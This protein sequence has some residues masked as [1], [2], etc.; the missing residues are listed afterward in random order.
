MKLSKR[1]FAT[2]KPVIVLPISLLFIGQSLQVF[3]QRVGIG[4][5]QPLARLAID[6]GLMVDQLSANMGSL[7]P[8]VIFGKEGLIG[9]ASSRL[10][11]SAYRNSLTFYTGGLR[12]MAI[13]SFGYVGI[14]VAPDQ[15]YRFYVNGTTRITT[16]LQVGTNLFVGNRLM[17]NTAIPQ[18]ALLYLKGRSG[19]PTGWGAHIVME[20]PSTTETGA[21][22]YD[23]DMKFRV[24][25]AGNGYFFR[26]ENNANLM[27][28]SSSGI[29]VGSRG[30]VKSNNSDQLQLVPYLSPANIDFTL[31]PGVS[32][33]FG[34]IYTAF[35]SPPIISPAH[36]TGV[37]DASHLNCTA[38][39]IT[40]TGATIVV[41][42]VGT[43]AVTATNARFHA[44]IVG[45]RN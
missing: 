1:C 34:I 7:S 27:T 25:G 36:W 13:D 15:A 2:I 44:I 29:T 17:L 28:I 21:I 18:D 32:V 31:N 19:T 41:R 16:E 14:N 4:T 42:N 5:N 39:N 37:T 45:E 12:R 35:T 9:I 20:A 30:I 24:F 11:A 3:S 26:D 8:G 38:T 22:L 43:A 23:G 6:S 33:S 40:T 10:N